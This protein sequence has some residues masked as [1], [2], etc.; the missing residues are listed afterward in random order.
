M[1]AS[2]YVIDKQFL[3]D[4]YLKVANYKKNITGCKIKRYLFSVHIDSYK[5]DL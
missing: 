1:M 2:Y 3:N 5:L 4:L